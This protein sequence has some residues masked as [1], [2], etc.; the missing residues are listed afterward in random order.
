MIL[1][2]SMCLPVSYGNKADTVKAAE[3]EIINGEVGDLNNDGSVNIIDLV[4]LK[5]REV[6]SLTGA[7]YDLNNDGEYDVTDLLLMRQFLTEKIVAFYRP[8]TSAINND[9]STYTVTDEL[10]RE[11]T[12]VKKSKNKKVGIRY[13]LHFGTGE[14]NQLYDVSNVLG[15]NANAASSADAWTSAGGGAVGAWHWWSQ[16]LFGYYLST[17]EWVIAKDVQMLTDAG[18]DFIAVDTSAD[19][20]YENQLV[21]LMSALAKYKNQGFVVPKVA[22]TDTTKVADAI[23]AFKAKYPEYSGLWYETESVADMTK[24]TVHVAENVAAAMSASAFY[25][26]TG[27]HTRSFDGYSNSSD[28]NAAIEGY[29][30][31]HEFEGAIKSGKSTIFIESWNEWISARKEATNDSQPIL[32][33]SNADMNNSSDIQ[34][35]KDGYGDDYYMQMVDY[36]KQYKG[37]FVTNTNLNTASATANTSIDVNGNFNQWNKVS[38]HYQDYTSDIEDRSAGGYSNDSVTYED[39]H[40]AAIKINKLN[41]NSPMS[42]ITKEAY[43]GGSTVSFKAYVPESEGWWAVSWTTDPKDVGL[44]KWTSGSGKSMTSVSGQWSDYSVTLPNDGKNYYVYIVG[45]KGEWPKG[46]GTA[47]EILVDDFRITSG[48]T[49][50]KENFDNG[51]EN[52]IFSINGS[53]VV[54][55]ETVKEIKQNKVAAIDIDQINDYQNMNFITKKAYKG[56]SKITFKALIPEDTG[57]TKVCLTTDNT[58]GD[59]YG[60]S[61]AAGSQNLNG[62]PGEWTEYSIT[63]PEGDDEY[64]VYFSGAKGEWKGKLL[65]IDDFKVEN[66]EN[67]EVDNFDSG[68]ADGLFDVIAISPGNG[69]T[70]VS[71]MVAETSGQKIIYTDESGQNDISRMKMTTD[72]I[73]LYAYVETVD[74][75]KGFGN[76]NC[77][78]L[79]ISTGNSGG[80]YN[81]YEYVVNRNSQNAADNKL[82]VEKYVAGEWVEAGKAA[83][84]MAGNKMQLSIPLST[85]GLEDSFKI[86]FKWA[87]NYSEDD[88]YS[89]YTKGDAAPYGRLNYT[90]EVEGQAVAI[91]KQYI[92]DVAGQMSIITKNKYAG[93][94]VVTFDA[95]VPEGINWWGICWTTDKSDTGLYKWTSAEGGHGQTMTSSIGEWKSYSVTLP[96]DSNKYYI[97]FVVDKDKDCTPKEPMLIDNFTIQSS[98]KTYVDTFNGGLHNGL[99]DI[100]ETDSSGNT[101]VSL[102]TTAVSKT[103]KAAAVDI[104]YIMADAKTGK[105]LITN[106]AYPAGSTLKFRAYVPEG[107]PWWGVNYV[108]SPELGD[109]YGCTAAG[110]NMLDAGKT[111]KWADYSITLPNDGQKYYLY[112]GGAKSE[113]NHKLLVIDDVKIYNA[114]GKV[115]AKDNFNSGLDKGIF[116]VTAVTSGNIVVSLIDASDAGTVQ[117]EESK[118]IE[119]AAYNAPTVNRT[120]SSDDKKKLDDAYEKLADAGFTKAIALTEGCPGETSGTPTA[121][122]IQDR[123]AVTENQA[124]V[125]LD[126]A[127]KYDIKYLVKD[128]SFYGL[129]ASN[130]DDKYAYNS[131]QVSTDEQFKTV[132]E[133]VFDAD[134]TYVNHSAYAGNFAFDEPYYNDLEAVATQYKYFSQQQEALGFKGEMFVNLYGSYI[135]KNSE[136]MGAEGLKDQIL[137]NYTYENYVDTYLSKVGTKLGYISWDNYP[138]MTENH[139]DKKTRDKNYLSNF[140]LIANKCKT[141]GVE[142]RTVIQS[143]ADDTGLRSINGPEDLRYQFY[144]G[145]AFGTREFI[146]YQYQGTKNNE[147]DTV[148]KDPKNFMYDYSDQTYT[149]VYD[150]AKEVNTEVHALEDVYSQYKWADVMYKKGSGSTHNVGLDNLTTSN[151]SGVY[152]DVA[153]NDCNQDT[154]VGI[155]NAKDSGSDR[156]NAYMFVNVADPTANASDEVTVKFA[157]GTKSV[158]VWQGGVRKTVNVSD[159]TYKFTLRAGE[160]AFIIPLK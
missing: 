42:F 11:M 9:T 87:D 100:T 88:I 121:Q 7:K 99:F 40:M 12:E 84:S 106:E 146:Y 149:Q 31:A 128:W 50:V 35:M 119:I 126:I 133:N 143:S 45:A 46:N 95:F 144:S 61:G 145:L 83:Y 85:L 82:V 150:W 80:C 54:R 60:D 3:S 13:F 155:F 79:F 66:G 120:T 2:A 65:L 89:F 48:S 139:A 58:K 78:S 69:S 147:K 63:L 29:N 103:N 81:Q 30:F 142:L 38:T 39:N 86:E 20:I 104:D 22:F 15:T 59:I 28:E 116:N 135:K 160:G 136:Q 10:D 132:I 55:Q 27:N 16:P 122:V 56:G 117:T 98:D 18:M 157:D 21:C 110:K 4:C 19:A 14:N 113:W 159:S 33:E 97:Y 91:E 25:G 101:A 123:S 37:A 49:V 151:K 57:W 41:E 17:D 138:F 77:M 108:T 24:Y 74:A 107:S 125:I 71:S 124:A 44:Y 152:G 156:Q 96:N 43:P 51:L 73:N 118:G 158:A 131:S 130:S 105:N 140:E 94:S 26:E 6:Q 114:D 72:G 70:V 115:I 1:V 68:I 90:Y 32:L 52:S 129:G 34:P 36:I 75:I 8:D 62:T 67:V 134:N 109:I 53:D 5:K 47:L 111:G 64:Y 148:S 76:A 102:K 137:G 23:S 141:N 92:S 154:L 112:F 93:G 153:I 127:K